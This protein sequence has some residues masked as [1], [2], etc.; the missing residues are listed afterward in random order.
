MPLLTLVI[1]TLMMLMAAPCIIDCLA[2][3]V[4]AQVN[5]LQHASSTRIYETIADHGKWHSP[6]DGHSYKDSEA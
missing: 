2:H 1:T 6:L 3:F 5:K 4:S